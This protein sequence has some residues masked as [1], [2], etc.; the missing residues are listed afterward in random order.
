VTRIGAAATL[1]AAGGLLVSGCAED[2][3]P[4]APSVVVLSRSPE[5]LAIGDDERNDLALVL[6]YED[7]AADLGDGRILVHDCR[8]PDLVAELPVPPIASEEAIRRGVAI[9]GT[10]DVLVADVGPVTAEATGLPETCRA[11]GVTPLTPGEAV[12]CV[13]LEDAGGQ[14]GRGDCAEPVELE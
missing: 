5:T 10:L 1:L 12:F 14:R 11:L 4:G 3:V 13:V 2:A 9:T 8:R 6:R 7:G